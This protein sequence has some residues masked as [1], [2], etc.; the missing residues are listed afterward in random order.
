MPK[1]ELKRYK[2]ISRMT[3]EV[4]FEG[5]ASECARKFNTVCDTIHSAAR[6]GVNICQKRYFVVECN[7]IEIEPETTLSEAARKWDEF[8]E[9]IRRRYNIPVYKAK[10]EVRG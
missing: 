4:V 6:R 5:T 7:A 1:K 10:P 9:P 8:C 2:I 3:G